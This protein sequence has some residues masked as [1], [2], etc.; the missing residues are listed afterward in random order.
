MECFTDLRVKK[1]F[2]LKKLS[3]NP[4]YNGMF[5]RRVKSLLSAITPTSV[6]IL[7][8]M[9]CFTDRTEKSYGRIKKSLNPYYNGC[10]TDILFFKQLQNPAFSFILIH[11][12]ITPFLQE[13]CMLFYRRFRK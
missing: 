1:K 9:E 8:I 10:I 13:I 12:Y 2:F 5:Y 7:I 3:L 6:L 4:Y 11:L